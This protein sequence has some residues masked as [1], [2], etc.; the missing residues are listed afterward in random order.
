[1]EATRCPVCKAEVLG[2]FGRPGDVHDLGDHLAE[3][4][5]IDDTDAYHDAAKTA[6]YEAAAVIDGYRS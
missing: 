4:H 6:E 2:P 5:D 1:M 3:V